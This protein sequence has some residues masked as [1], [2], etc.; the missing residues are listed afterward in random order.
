MTPSSSSGWRRHDE[1]GR[2]GAA[3]GGSLPPLSKPRI[4]GLLA[5]FRDMGKAGT[6][7]DVIGIVYAGLSEP[8]FAGLSVDQTEQVLE[9]AR[10][11][12]TGVTEI[13]A[14]KAVYKATY[15]HPD[16]RVRAMLLDV[17]RT[18][19]PDEKWAKKA[20]TKAIG[21]STDA[22]AIKAIDMAG[23]FN[24]K[25]TV[26]KLMQMVIAKWGQHVGVSAAKATR[27]L[28]KITGASKPAGWH[29]WVNQHL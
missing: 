3:S 5:V 27:A 4:S 24:L 18:R 22:V 13:R 14:W 2:R 26:P 29:A 8:T 15:K 20:V 25:Q 12:L 21:D 16:W 28:E 19:L 6:K 7:A 10:V 17:M 1:L 9:T 11:V 23:E